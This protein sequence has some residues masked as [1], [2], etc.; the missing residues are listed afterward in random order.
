M[1]SQSSITELFT[2]QRDGPIK[3]KADLFLTLLKGGF[4]S[5]Q[6]LLNTSYFASPTSPSKIRNDQSK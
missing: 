3:F 2:E 5:I 6:E 1:V 4:L